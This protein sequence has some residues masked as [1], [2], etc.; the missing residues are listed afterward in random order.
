MSL[1]KTLA[2]HLTHVSVNQHVVLALLALRVLLRIAVFT[3]LAY[4]FSS[5]ITSRTLGILRG[6]VTAADVASDGAVAWK[7]IG[8]IHA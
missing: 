6:V 2:T 4:P 8:T 7:L 3:F 5:L 1:G